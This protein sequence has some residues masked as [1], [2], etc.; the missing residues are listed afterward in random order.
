MCPAVAEPRTLSAEE[1]QLLLAFA[2]TVADSTAHRRS[3]Y[4]FDDYISLFPP[5]EQRRVVESLRGSGYPVATDSAYW[6]G[7]DRALRD[8][9]AGIYRYELVE[10]LWIV[11]GG[12]RVAVLRDAVLA[13]RYGVVGD[14]IAGHLCLASPTGPSCI[15]QQ[16][17]RAGYNRAMD[18][19]VGRLFGTSNLVR[20]ATEEGV[21]RYASCNVTA[22]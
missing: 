5:E 17:G 6:E 13:Q 7:F 1:R 15:V 2:S 19:T 12:P 8:I 21:D 14:E 3:T 10:N 20:T 9:D 16:A 18:L 4:H 22:P 11:N